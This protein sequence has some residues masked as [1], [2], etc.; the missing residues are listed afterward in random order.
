MH[1]ITFTT[2]T[3]ASCYQVTQR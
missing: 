1:F 2:V 3:N